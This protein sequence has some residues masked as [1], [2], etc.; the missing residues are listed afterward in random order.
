MPEDMETMASRH[1]GDA[2]RLHRR[3]E[4]LPARLNEDSPA[5]DVIMIRRIPPSVSKGLR[6]MELADRR[7]G[8][9]TAGSNPAPATT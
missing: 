3:V 4:Y 2:R 7:S 8:E 9:T 6:D 5:E 1:S